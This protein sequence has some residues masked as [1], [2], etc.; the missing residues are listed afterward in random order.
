METIQE[1]Y[2]R[3]QR[4]KN[5]RT[6]RQAG[7]L[8][9]LTGGTQATDCWALE[10]AGF[11]AQKLREPITVTEVIPTTNIG[12]YF[13]KLPSQLADERTV[14]A[15][16]LAEPLRQRGLD[17]RVRVFLSDTTVTQPAE[18]NTGAYRVVIKSRY[19]GAW[20]IPARRGASRHNDVQ[21]RGPVSKRLLL[22]QAC[23]ELD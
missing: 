17:V 5:P 1:A 11:L 19:G 23:R 10:E 18:L 9:D 22:G 6:F 8:V 20:R 13:Q 3:S 7:I 4:P 15:E 21:V 12:W 16:I 2:E 14:R